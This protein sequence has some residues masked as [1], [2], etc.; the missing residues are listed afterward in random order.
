MGIL[1]IDGNSVYEVDEECLKT[2][3]MPKD[4]MLP[5]EVWDYLNEKD[6]SIRIDLDTKK[7]E[8]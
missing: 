5:R 1:I 4:C 8:S 6:G 3:K 2:H 7:K